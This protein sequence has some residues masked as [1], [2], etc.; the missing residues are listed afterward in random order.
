VNRFLNALLCLLTVSAGSAR[1]QTVD[2]FLDGAR[3][4][5]SVD[6]AQ[7]DVE[8]AESS[9]RGARFALLPSLEV[10]GTYTR[11]QFPQA[12]TLPAPSGP[13][14]EV[15]IMARDQL[16]AV[17]GSRVTLLDV[18]AWRRLGGTD[19]ALE[20]AEAGA[21]VTLRRL[22]RDVLTEFYR[23]VGGSAL[24]GSSE[25]QLEVAQ[26]AH[27]LMSVR[28]EAGLATPLDVER[29]ALDVLVAEQMVL[30]ARQTQ[31]QAARALELLTGVRATTPPELE[32]STEPPE[33][34][35]GMLV[36]ASQIPD[37][38]L[39]E[40]SARAA[41]AAAP[42]LWYAF[43]P[44]VDALFTEELT[45]APAFGQRARWTLQIQAAWRIDLASLET[46][47]ANVASANAANSRARATSLA[48][49][50]ALGRAHLQVETALARTTTAT[51]RLALARRTFELARVE[52]GAGRVTT[53]T[54]FQARRDF[55]DA[56]ANHVSSVAELAL[57]R[58]LL[59]LAGS[60]GSL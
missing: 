40:A 17:F 1:A 29:A 32:A 50:D 43:V 35:E 12:F 51:A 59:R 25:E 58:H 23:W 9:A 36:D 48:A 2:E 8:V 34:L 52:L 5:P 18:I 37:V 31:L 24:L 46:L 45:N 28:M 20:A 53:L 42:P 54:F 41:D 44:R 49:V 27:R 10:T 7:S 22:E 14:Q 11:N 15:T 38:A 30:E 57:A 56:A 16:D 4:H 13:G 60:A 6:A 3:E 21:Q 47:R 19:A 39:A 26:A 33:P 55:A